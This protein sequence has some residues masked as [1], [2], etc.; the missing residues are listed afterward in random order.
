[1]SYA[2]QLTVVG[3]FYRGHPEIAMI[4]TLLCSVLWALGVGAARR[5]GGRAVLG[6]FWCAPLGV[7]GVLAAGALGP[8]SGW[9]SGVL[10]LVCISGLLLCALHL[11]LSYWLARRESVAGFWGTLLALPQFALV[12]LAAALLL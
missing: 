9:R 4:G 6:A 12:A 10:A 5:L 8:E 3:E 11:A 1:M 2:E 7:G